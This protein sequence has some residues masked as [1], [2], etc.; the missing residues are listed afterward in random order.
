[1]KNVDNCKLWFS[2]NDIEIASVSVRCFHAKAS[3]RSVSTKSAFSI[4]FSVE[5]DFGVLCF[6]TRQLCAADFIIGLQVIEIAK[7]YFAN[8][9]LKCHE[10]LSCGRTKTGKF[11]NISNSVTKLNSALKCPQQ[12]YHL[13]MFHLSRIYSCHLHH[14]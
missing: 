5:I 13:L 9:D 2:Q 6:I 1:M 8:L 12:A 11:S 14:N 4:L 10:N 3:E 7:S